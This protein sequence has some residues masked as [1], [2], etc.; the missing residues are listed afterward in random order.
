MIWKRRAG[1]YRE[2]D[3]GGSGPKRG[4]TGG[5]GNVKSGGEKLVLPPYH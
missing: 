2:K 5:T 3:N 1:G 4:N